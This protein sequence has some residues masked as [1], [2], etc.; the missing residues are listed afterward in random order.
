MVSMKEC[1]RLKNLSSKKMS[2]LPGRYKNRKN[3][4]LTTYKCG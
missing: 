2:L 3:K 1:V 4:E